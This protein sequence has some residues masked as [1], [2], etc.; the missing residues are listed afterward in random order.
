MRRLPQAVRQALKRGRMHL[1]PGGV[2]SQ[3]PFCAQDVARER[4]RDRPW[5]SIADNLDRGPQE[6]RLA[7]FSLVG[8]ESR[9]RGAIPKTSPTSAAKCR[10]FPRVRGS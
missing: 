9:G 5:S 10:T 3:Y 2:L 8:A 7:A 6:A 1:P 4:L